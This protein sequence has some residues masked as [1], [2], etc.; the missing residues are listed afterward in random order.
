MPVIPFPID[1]LAEVSPVIISQ[2]DT[3]I[4]IAIEVSRATLARHRRFL[5]NLLAAA[6][7]ARDRD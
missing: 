3:H 1:R 7:A 4:L 2:S 6:E 5:E